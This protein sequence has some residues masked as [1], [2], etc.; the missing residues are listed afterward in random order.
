[1]ELRKWNYF[2]RKYDDYTVPDTWNVTLDAPENRIYSCAGCGSAIS[3]ETAYTSLEIHDSIGLGYLV[4]EECSALE[5][6]RRKQHR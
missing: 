4:C 1:M 5:I 3:A 2:S 6:M